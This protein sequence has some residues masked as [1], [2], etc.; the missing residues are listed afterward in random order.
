MKRNI[1]AMLLAAI[2]L[3]SLKANAQNRVHYNNQDLFLSGSNLA[4]NNYGTDIG[5]GTTD[6]TTIGNW[7]LQMHQHGGNA[8]RMWMDVEGKNGY[9]FDVHGRATGLAPNTISDLKKVLKIGWDREIGL[10]FCLWGFGMLNSALDTSILNRNKKILSDTSY[11]NAYIR[12]C[13]IPMVKALKGNPALISWEIFNEPE[14][15]STEFGWTSGPRT[16]MKNIQKFVNLLAGGIHKADP[17]AKVTSGAVTLATLTDVPMPMSKSSE[18]RL[19]LA[20]MSIAQK[21]NLED[22]FNNKYKL[23]LSA[24]E[25]VPIIQNLTAF[26]WNFY[27]DDRLIAAGHDTLGILDFYSVHYYT[28]SNPSQLSPFTHPASK[29]ALTKPLVVAEFGM[30]YSG[31]LFVD[32]VKTSEL[33]DTLYSNGYAGA[34]PWS[35]SDHGFS[36]QS[37]M[38]AG[39]QS[40]WNKHKSAVDLLGIGADW[41][42]ISISSPQD[43]SII[44]TGSKVAITATVT[45]S[46]KINSVDFYAGTNKIGTVTTSPYIYNWS[47]A[48]GMYNLTAVATNILG[49]QQTSGIIQITVGTSMTRIEAE[50]AILKGPG[51]K[52]VTDNTASGHKYVDIQAADSTS[53]ITWTIPNVTTAGTYQIAFGFRM[54]YGI[55]KTQYLNINGIRAD[56]ILF[57][58]TSSSVWYEISKNVTLVAGSNTIQMQMWWS[59]MQLDFL[60]VSE[61]IITAVENKDGLPTSYS[62]SQNYPNPFNPATNIRYTVPKL[63]QVVMKVYDVLGREVVTLVNEVK[64]AGSYITTFNGRQLSSGIYFYT[65]RAGDFVQSKKMVIMK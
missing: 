41:P 57:N 55:P 6:T 62:L 15:M 58:G 65:L 64:N 22:W 17:T 53:T 44:T 13:L 47:P 29:W 37:E 26:D 28:M 40:I 25:I 19:N 60:D 56:S 5:L 21:K 63:S 34:L 32:G 24:A 8:M 1:T 27:R 12:N 43:G 35:W 39:M 38:I 9:T 51:M 33:F 50:T 11:T 4:W 2:M 49:H 20:T 59:Y 7:M 23:N 14:G 54:P 30:E 31:S 16:P 18:Q 3:F 10:N 46:M 42:I 36:T 61:S 45:D 48:D 52:V